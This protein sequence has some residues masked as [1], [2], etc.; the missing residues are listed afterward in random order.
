LT[1]LI[2]PLLTAINPGPKPQETAMRDLLRSLVGVLGIACLATGLT[3]LS[4]GHALAQAKQAPPSQM[5]PAQP[6]PPPLKQMALTDKQIDGVLA[7]QKDMDAITQKLPPNAPPSP[8]AVAQLD[9]VAKKNGF[10][11]YDQ[12]N[13]VVENITMVLSG[14]DPVS[15]KYVGFEAATKA[16]IAQVQ[17]NKQMSAKDKKDA[18]AELNESLKSPPPAVENKGN[19][20]LVGKNYDKLADALGGGQQ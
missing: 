13:D 4:T 14:F 1:G 11:S 2:R 6:A 10:A 8:K 19:I 16:Q 9:A 12:Y 5:A 7:A 15:K 18:L 17:A 3:A 20:D